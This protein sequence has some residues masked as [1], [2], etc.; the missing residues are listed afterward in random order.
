MEDSYTEDQFKVED[1]GEENY[2]E[3]DDTVAEIA[4]KDTKQ[5]EIPV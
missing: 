4:M 3:V 1:D 2:S 5:Q